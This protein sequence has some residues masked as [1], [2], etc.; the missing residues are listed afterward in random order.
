MEP[1][2]NEFSYQNACRIA[3]RLH[4]VYPAFSVR[5]FSRGLQQALEPLE[6]KQRMRLLAERIEA[7]LPAHPPELFSDSRKSPCGRRTRFRWPPRIPR[8]AAH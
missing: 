3:T 5:K 7:G 4:Q 6:L 1:F 2:K 8:L